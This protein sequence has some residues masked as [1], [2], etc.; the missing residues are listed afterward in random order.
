MAQ[1]AQLRIEMASIFASA[2]LKALGS[3][4]AT[5]TPMAYCAN[6]FRKKRISA[7]M[8]PMNSVL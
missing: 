3:A 1:H 5:K 6:T 4:E 8:E 2:T 7:S